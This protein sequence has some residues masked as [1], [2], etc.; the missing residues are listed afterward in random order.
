MVMISNSRKSAVKNQNDVPKLVIFDCDGVLVD[1]E[2][3]SNRHIHRFLLSR[4]ADITFSEC[5]EIFSGKSRYD[6]ERYLTE[7]G[8]EIPQDW[9][10]SFSKELICDLKKEVE[11]IHGVKKALRI[12][13]NHKIEFCVASNGLLEKMYATLGKTGMLP[14]FQG[15]MFSAHEVGASKPAPDVFLHAAAVNRTLPEHCLVVEDSAS[16]FEAAARA[17]MSCLAYMPK[18]SRPVSNLFGARQF[19]DMA[20]LPSEL[21][22]VTSTHRHDPAGREAF[23]SRNCCESGS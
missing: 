21:G 15:N 14:W 13:M 16:G 12:L 23:V 5:C 17:G 19:S 6:V 3:I 7:K 22:L 18:G 1:S 10:F 8:L 2:A 11:P 4:G 9:L 20:L